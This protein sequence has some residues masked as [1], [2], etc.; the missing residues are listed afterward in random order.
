MANSPFFP[1]TISLVGQT[2]NPATTQDTDTTQSAVSLGRQGDLLISG[3]RQTYGVMAHRG[4]VFWGGATTAGIAIP[5]NTTTSGST[6]A[7]QNPAGSGVMAELI[8][9]DLNV[10][11]AGV[12]SVTTVGFSIVNNATNAASAVSGLAGPIRAG[13]NPSNFAG[14]TPSCI[15]AGAITFASALTVAANWGIGLFSFGVS[16]LPTA[17][18]N[19]GPFHYAFN[20]KVC[21][22]PGW[23]I[24]LTA[25]AAWGANTAIPSMSWAEY[26]L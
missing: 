19:T 6:F 2:A 7:L 20:G 5:I 12:A 18:Y 25:T 13:G 15:L 16:Y 23:S 11:A 10:L 22:P 14:G 9:F 26:K 21:V 3:V 17:T 1:S 4:N 8:D 24:T